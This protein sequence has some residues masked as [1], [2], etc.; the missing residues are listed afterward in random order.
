MN[1]R[2]TTIITVPVA[3]EGAGEAAQMTTKIQEA[4]FF[5][6]K[7]GVAEAC[8]QSIS[9]LLLVHLD[10]NACHIVGLLHP[11]AAIP[12]PIS[13]LP[14][15]P[16]GKVRW[17]TKILKVEWTIAAPQQ[18]KFSHER[19]SLTNEELTGGVQTTQNQCPPA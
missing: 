16:F 3:R 6:I 12:F 10:E 14:T 11:A 8:R 18:A 7:N 2:A 13:N 5:R 19:I 17:P 15:I 9:A 4:P 1:V